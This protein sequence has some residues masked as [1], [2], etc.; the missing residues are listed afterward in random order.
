ME[1]SLADKIKEYQ[2]EAQEREAKRLA[3]KYHLPYLD[4]SIY[5][6]DPEAL[7]LLERETVEKYKILPIYH[8]P[9][10]VY[11]A[12]LDPTLK[13][14]QEIIEEFKKQGYEVKVFVVSQWAFEEVLKEREIGKK[15]KKQLLKELKLKKKIF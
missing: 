13:G 8:T 12:L 9:R 5:P 15:E 11:F 6:I 7:R 14:A 4:L 1:D 3:E 10:K 2:K